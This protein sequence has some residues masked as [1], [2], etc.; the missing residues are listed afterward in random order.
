LRLCGQLSFFVD[1]VSF[2]VSL[3]LSFDSIWLRLRRARLFAVRFSYFVFFVAF[4]V[5]T[6]F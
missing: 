1:F 3:L 4:V 2:V 5:H 6:V